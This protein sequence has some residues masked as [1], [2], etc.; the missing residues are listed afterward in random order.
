MTAASS[1][2]DPA[3]WGAAAA[4]AILLAAASYG[5]WRRAMPLELFLAAILAAALAWGTGFLLS[6]RWA[7]EGVLAAGRDLT[8]ETATAAIPLLVSPV[9]LEAIGLDPKD[10]SFLKEGLTVESRGSSGTAIAY[11]YAGL[12]LGGSTGRA[13]LVA[14]FLGR[15]QEDLPGVLLAARL[16]AA[17]TQ[18]D[19]ASILAADLPPLGRPSRLIL[20]EIIPELRDR[21]PAASGLLADLLRRAGGSEP[22]S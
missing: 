13:E 16:L 8:P 9:H 1:I 17:R 19:I 15:A 21:F 18:D 2:P 14:C 6:R 10:G 4:G 12:S 5:A 20:R 11:D 22:R 3:H 7:L